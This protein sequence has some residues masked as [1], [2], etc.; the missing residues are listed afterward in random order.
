MMQNYMKL[1][2]WLMSVTPFLS[3][4]FLTYFIH[5]S[6]WEKVLSTLFFLIV[7]VAIGAVA[8]SRCLLTSEKWYTLY[9]SAMLFSVYVCSI[10]FLCLV[11]MTVFAH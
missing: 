3:A 9:L 8:S 10:I 1:F 11:N 5:A 6:K 4:Y 2:Y 7:P